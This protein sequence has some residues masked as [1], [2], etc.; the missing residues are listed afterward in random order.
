[1]KKRKTCGCRIMLVIPFLLFTGLILYP[2]SANRAF[3]AEPE[4]VSQSAADQDPAIDPEALA[5]MK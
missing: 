1:M 5:I 3:A 2:G 4:H